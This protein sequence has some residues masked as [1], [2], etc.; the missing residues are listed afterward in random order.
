MDTLPDDGMTIGL[1]PIGEEYDDGL[2][3]WE[4]INGAWRWMTSPSP[5]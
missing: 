5:D 4:V 1:P 2:G 3:W